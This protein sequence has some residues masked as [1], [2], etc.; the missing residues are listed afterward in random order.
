MYKKKNTMERV[1]LKELTFDAIMEG[2]TDAIRK[3]IKDFKRGDI[4]WIEIN[5]YVQKEHDAERGYDEFQL[6]VARTTRGDF[7]IFYDM[8]S[9]FWV[10]A[11]LDSG[12]NK[13]LL[14]YFKDELF[15]A[16]INGDKD[17][18]E[19]CIEAIK[20]IESGK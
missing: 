4:E 1:Y 5:P 3:G 18:E 6:I 8:R 10:N 17:L 2:C 15:E 14:E 13:E 9:D 11:A 19:Q 12:W 20:E 7:E 16:R